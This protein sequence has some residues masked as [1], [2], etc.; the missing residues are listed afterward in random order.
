M[1]AR[2][3]RTKGRVRGRGLPTV[4]GTV[5]VA[6]VAAFV[7]LLAGWQLAGAAFGPSTSATPTPAALVRPALIDDSLRRAFS[8][9]G[10]PGMWLLC[11]SPAPLDCRPVEPVRL[12][13]AIAFGPSGRLWSSLPTVSLAIGGRI[14]MA[15]DMS[16]AVGVSFS[17]VSRGGPA[18]P[19]PATVA[20]GDGMLYLDIGVLPPGRYMVIGRAELGPPAGGLVEAV[21]VV[22][23][24][25]SR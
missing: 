13:P 10:S 11:R 20:A 23:S 18:A 21:E 22:I 15:A 1:E 25:A 5:V 4:P 8:A 19:D 16:H 9:S 2:P 6:L 14:S 17:V 12:A 3:Q 24:S 7:G